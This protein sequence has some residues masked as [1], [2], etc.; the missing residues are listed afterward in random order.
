VAVPSDE[1][2]PSQTQPED[3]QAAHEPGISRRQILLSGGIATGAGLVFVAP[4][5]VSALSR[6]H[7]TPALVH[8]PDAA[9]APPP[10]QL[11]VQFGADA[12]TQAAVSWATA[13][14]VA[15][16]RLRLGKTDTGLGTEIPAAERTY[17]EAM[18]GQAVY[19]YHALA[20]R[21]TPDTAYVYQALH[22]GAHPVTGSFHTGP[23][24]RSKGFRFTSFGDQSIPYKITNI[25]PASANAGYV[26]DAVDALDPLFHLMNG[27]LSYANSSDA[28]VGQWAAFFTNNMRSARNRPWMPVLGNHENEVGNGPQGF[29]AYQTRFE[30]PGNGSAEFRN[31]WY[32][33]TVGSIRFVAISNDDVCI[34]DG[35][36]STCRRD[37]VPGYRKRGLNPYIRG[38]SHGQQRAWL[39]AELAAARQDAGIDWLVVVMHQVVMS[40][41]HFNGADLGIRQAFV[42]LFDRY[43]VDLI[44]AGHEHHF[45]RTFP[46]RGIL[47]GSTVLTPAPQQTNPAVIDTRH[48]Y[49]HMIIG[50]GGNPHPTHRAAFD[51][52]HDGVVTVGLGPGGPEKQREHIH[53]TEPAPWSAYRDLITPYGF[54]SFDV[55][56]SEPGGTTSITVTHYGAAK[57]SPHYSVRDRFVLRKPL[58]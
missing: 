11:H 35:G 12:A 7:G 36:F 50:G 10:T 29:L 42:P 26:V 58:A 5:V 6:K 47:P 16:P 23:A 2:P 30:L 48:G 38:Y 40:S 51:T 25:G 1:T 44:I 14:R 27:D 34:E 21:L 15:R 28:P 45:E 13:S 32:A 55:V 37:Y 3:I 41:A 31:F 8:R 54:A 20:D 53:V 49:V 46:V 18:T 9:G 56:P 43:G 24:G 19:T 39:E 57:G 17:T 22:D 4:A 52:P 33:F